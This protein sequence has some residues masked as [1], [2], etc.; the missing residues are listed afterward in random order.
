[1]EEVEVGVKALSSNHKFSRRNFHGLSR[2]K[3]F[4]GES[5]NF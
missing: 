3:N 2:V 1:M 4:L 5:T